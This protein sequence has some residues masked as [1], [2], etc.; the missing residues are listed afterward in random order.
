MS[1]AQRITD[2][3]TRIATE[4]KS[5][6]TLIAGNNTGSLSGLTTTAKTSILAAVNELKSDQANF[7]PAGHVGSGGSAHAV[8]TT[9]SAGFMS[10]NDK[11]KLDSLSNYTKFRGSYADL[12]ALTAAIPTAAA[13]DWAILTVTGGPSKIALWDTDAGTPAWVEAGSAATGGATNLSVSRD[14]TTVTVTSDTGA[15]ASLPGAS[16]TNAGIMTAADKVKLDATLSNTQIGDP[17]TD[18]VSTFNTGLN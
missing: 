10:A 2:L 8:A 5:I 16:T 12:A 14:A 4:F 7:A 18:F 13:G 17:E 11:T 3:T 15:D 1:L 9:S 6:K